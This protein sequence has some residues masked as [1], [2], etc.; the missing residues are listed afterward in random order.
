MT[1]NILKSIPYIVQRKEK[2][3]TSELGNYKYT[4][5]RKPDKTTR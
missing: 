4:C 5:Y 2:S 3:N 1:Q